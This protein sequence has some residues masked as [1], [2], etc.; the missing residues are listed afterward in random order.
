MSEPWPGC[1]GVRLLVE[2]PVDV[3]HGQGSPLAEA[4]LALGPVAPPVGEELW[5]LRAV[6]ETVTGSE[7]AEQRLFREPDD[8]WVLR[9][10]RGAALAVDPIARTIR[11]DGPDDGTIAQ[12][13][14]T[15]GF[16]LLLHGRDV[17]IVHAAAVARDGKAVLIAGASGSGKSSTLV[18]L[19]D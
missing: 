5:Q 9:T 19:V 12:L 10:N 1:H 2:P 15:Y 16:P 7:Q 13:V 8:S 4:S 18:R 3:G 17:V 6:V 14:A 11:A